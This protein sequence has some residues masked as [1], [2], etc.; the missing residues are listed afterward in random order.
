[1]QRFELTQKLRTLVL[2]AGRHLHL[3]NSTEKLAIT[4]AISQMDQTKVVHP[5]EVISVY[6]VIIKKLKDA[7]ASELQRSYF[8]FDVPSLNSMARKIKKN[9]KRTRK[10]K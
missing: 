10:R 7:L 8:G 9:F 6:S 5:V 2:F 1:M 4:R 3:A